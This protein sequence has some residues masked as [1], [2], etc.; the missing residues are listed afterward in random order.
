MPI[1]MAPKR[2]NGRRGL[3]RNGPGKWWAG[4][5]LMTAHCQH[6]LCFIPLPKKQLSLIDSNYFP[7]REKTRILFDHIIEP[8][9]LLHFSQDG[10]RNECWGRSEFLGLPLWKWREPTNNSQTTRNQEKSPLM[11]LLQSQ[12]LLLD[13]NSEEGDLLEDCKS[14]VIYFIFLTK[15][16]SQRYSLSR[17]RTG[18][19][20]LIDAIAP[21]TTSPD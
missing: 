15:E 3:V 19:N 12:L 8:N 21:Q 14:K 18:V 2:L 13:Q 9:T 16:S 10:S 6:V 1:V 20:Y 4:L 11:S 7:P 5:E 17:V